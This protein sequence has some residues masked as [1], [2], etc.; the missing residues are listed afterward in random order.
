M[1]A[2]LAIQGCQQLAAS[3]SQPAEPAAAPAGV[4]D[5]VAAAVVAGVHPEAL[6][7]DLVTPLCGLLLGACTAPAGLG[8]APV[9]DLGQ[10]GPP[11]TTSRAQ[12]G[13]CT[14]S[15]ATLNAAPA[16]IK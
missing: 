9:A 8:H 16:Q 6:S 14:L 1:P 2:A 15:V 12:V 11:W 4:V 13:A 10:G 7:S 3:L 5:V